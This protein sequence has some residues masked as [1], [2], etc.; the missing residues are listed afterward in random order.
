M[1]PPARNSSR[2]RKRNPDNEERATGERLPAEVLG[3]SN[4]TAPTRMKLRVRRGD[5]AAASGGGGPV[6]ETTE[7]SRE[8]SRSSS[9][10][11]NSNKTSASA[12]A[13]A[14]SSSSPPTTSASSVRAVMAAEEASPDSKCPICLDRFNNLAY[15][16]HCLHR[17]CFPCIQEW[18]HNKAEC[19]LCKQPFA[20]ILH[21]VRAE[22]DFKEYT[23]QPPPTNNSVAATVAMVAAMASAARSDHHMRLMLRRHRVAEGRETTTRRRR[24]ERGAR[25]RGSEERA[26]GVWELYLDH[27]PLSF[28]PLSRHLSVSNVV[29]E[30]SEE[31]EELPAERGG[32][33]SAERGALLNE[34]TGLRG[35]AASLASNNRALRRLMTRL[36]ARQRLQREGGTMQRLRDGQMLDFRRMLYRC[37]IRVRGIAG[38]SG[39]TGQQ[40]D[41]TAES[42]HQSHSHLNRLRPW[43]RRELRVMYGSNSSLVDIVQNIIMARLALHGLENTLNLEEDL[44]PFLQART[45]H[46]LHELVSFARSPLNMD[47]YDL[48]AVYEPPPA[49]AMEL[50]GFSSSSEGSSVIAISEE[51]EVEERGGRSEGTV[52]NDLNDI[53]QTGSSLSLSGWDDETPGPSYSTAEPSCSLVPPL[54]LSP[55]PQEPA[56]E[57]GGDRPREEAEEE[58]LIVGYKKPIAERTPELVQLSSDTEEEEG[59]KKKKE[60]EPA[61][62]T[63]PLP[64]PT[65][66]SSYLPIIPPSTSGA[67]RAEQEAGQ[68]DEEVG[69]WRSRSWS[70]S[71]GRSRKSVCSLNLAAPERRRRDD[72]QRGRRRKKKNKKRGREE[73]QRRSGV[74]SNPNRS[75]YPPMMR[76]R[77]PPLFDSSA[78]SSLEFHC[79]QVSPI[80]SPSCSSPSS[81]LCLSPPQTPPTPSRSPAEHAH[82]AEKPG[83]K[84]KYKSRHL[85][86]STK[87]PSWRQSGGRPRERRKERRRRREKTRKEDQQE[88]GGL[89]EEGKRSR[90]DRSPSVE[91]IYEGTISS[92]ATRPLGHKRRRKRH[93]RPRHSSPPVIITL[94]SDS[95]HDGVT[96]RKLPSG[97]SSP[98]SSQQTIDFSDLPPLPLVHSAGVGGAL[99]ADIGELPAEILDRSSDGSEAAGPSAGRIHISDNSDVDV[100]NVEDDVSLLEDGDHQT[101]GEGGQT[102]ADNVVPGEH[103]ASPSDRYL[104][105]AILSDL[106]QISAAKQQLFQNLESGFSPTARIRAP[107]ETKGGP[108]DPGCDSQSGGSSAPS[109]P[110]LDVPPLLKRASPVRSY[111]RNTPPPLKHKDAGSPQ[112]T[113]MFPRCSSDADPVGVTNK[114][115]IPPIE[116]L[117]SHLRNVLALRGELPSGNSPPPS[118]PHHNPGNASH[119]TDPAHRDSAS[120]CDGI[121]TRSPDCREP[122]VDLCPPSRSAGADCKTRLSPA[123]AAGVRPESPSSPL[124][125]SCSA[126]GG[127]ADRR[128]AAG[129]LPPADGRL[130]HTAL[131]SSA[132]RHFHPS[133]ARS[134]QPHP[135]DSAPQPPANATHFHRDV[136]ILKDH[137]KTF[138]SPSADSNMSSV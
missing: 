87:D 11:K 136:Q 55:T 30:D 15:L 23:L 135:S 115:A 123:G 118:E 65:P 85:N 25:G 127:Q 113:A 13:A 137:Q 14:A 56:N 46:F 27:P 49:A 19:P 134:E 114:H 60:E 84:R 53:I 67:F 81:P 101:A 37:G 61:E 72:T 90:E 38:V 3:A 69:G 116:T 122:A 126:S 1:P 104:L 35:A 75:I 133:K 73:G 138:S 79:A 108:Q 129:F 91:I 119:S 28:P 82:H 88:N 24:R 45:E 54:S 10:R 95:S 86:S 102:H 12:T 125:S 51:E 103:R 77:S 71:S 8:G 29:A 78:D 59:E 32:A 36:A 70:G 40:R 34:L 9:R 128:T 80:S 83:G 117:K 92:S 94:D 50:D 44:R 121:R 64:S 112:Q 74:F 57:R 89:G 99:D 33:D 62:K 105:E 109:L 39:N 106:N 31:A 96:N 52:I 18:S 47:S 16:D 2:R 7:R 124:L 22:D 98:L 111:N 76:R 17:F 41:I 4:V 48:Q 132:V 42:F 66:S 107:D 131:P 130:N 43:L 5:G 97:S 120:R 110:P 93:R 68:K 100:E 6:E 20:S 58:C 63:P 26:G 21:S